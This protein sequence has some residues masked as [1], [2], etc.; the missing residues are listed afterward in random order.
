MRTCKI[1]DFALPLT[2]YWNWKKVKERINNLTLLMIKK[3]MWNIEI[4]FIPNVIDALGTVTKVLSKG[5][6]V[7]EIWGQVETIQ[8][9]AL[10]RLAR[11]LRR[12]LETWGDLRSLKLQWKNI[13]KCWCRN[14]S[15]S[16]NND[17]NESRPDDLFIVNKK[18]ITCWIVDFTVLADHRVKIKK[19]KKRNTYLDPSRGLRKVWTLK[20][21]VIPIVVGAFGLIPKGL[22]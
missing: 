22:V 17:N 15:R 9:T 3:K 19:I 2:T 12:V 20:E 18:N 7:L 16:K 5:T 4:A 1:V 13:R 10:F 6:E 21:T 11:I 14:L 8:T